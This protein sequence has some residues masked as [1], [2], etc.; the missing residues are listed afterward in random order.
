MNRMEFACSKLAQS[1]AFYTGKLVLL[2]TLLKLQPPSSIKCFVH[3][4]GVI[5]RVFCMNCQLLS[6]WIER[7]R[8]RKDEEKAPGR[9]GSE[10]SSDE[11]SGETRKT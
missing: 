7:R 10:G 1:G 5:G 2:L 6:G 9:H 11:C 3:R 4:T 8:V